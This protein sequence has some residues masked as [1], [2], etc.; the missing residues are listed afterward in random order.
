MAGEKASGI[1]A[2]PFTRKMKGRKRMTRRICI[3]LALI[4]QTMTIAHAEL[5]PTVREW[6]DITLSRFGETWQ[7]EAGM[8][9]GR[10]VHG[11]RGTMFYGLGLLQR[12]REE[13]R[14]RALKAIRS[15]C[16]QQYVASGTNYHGTFSRN[17]REPQPVGRAAPFIDFDPNWREFI[18]LSMILALEQCGDSVD[19]VTR[20]ATLDALRYACEGAYQRNVPWQY[21]NIS[22]MSAFLLSWGGNQFDN[23]EWKLRGEELSRDIYENFSKHGTFTEYNS[24]TYNGVNLWA[25][26]AWRVIGPTPEMV[27]MGTEMEAGLWRDIALS[28][29]AGLRN[30]CGPYDRS[31]AMDMQ[32]YFAIAGIAIALATESPASMPDVRSAHTHDMAYLP[33]LALLGL[34]VPEDAM[35]HLKSFQG[36]RHYDR[37]IEEGRLDRRAHSRLYETHMVGVQTTSRGRITSTQYHPFTVHWKGNNDAIYWIRFLGD[38]P[39]V[40]S[41]IDDAIDITYARTAASAL[42]FEVYAPGAETAS[43]NRDS[44]KLPG[45]TIKTPVVPVNPE[46]TQNN[47]TFMVS[48]TIPAGLEKNSLIMEVK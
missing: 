4:L 26:A 20:H 1:G 23:P 38:T 36:E 10:G 48:Y 45:I 27:A 9:G 40:I 28:Y 19:G 3:S 6:V 22:L 34:R 2:K 47:D 8:I 35:A 24:P 21:T 7:E 41:L 31:Q 11:T 33:L 17:D 44:W 12:G 39:V 14:E 18:G 42:R 37:I 15:V 16:K 29:H 5:S 46:V 32:Q 30:L 25:L 43:F 13:D